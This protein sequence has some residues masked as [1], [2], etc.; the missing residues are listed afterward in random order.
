MTAELP[1][2]LAPFGA[3]L[4]PFPR[5]LAEALGAMVGRLRVLVGPLARSEDAPEGELDGLSG[6]ARRG[7]LERLLVTDWALL[8]HEPDELLR[9]LATGELSYLALARRQEVA[10]RRTIALFDAGPAQLGGPR[11]AHLALA[12]LL[13]ARADAAGASFS[14]GSLQ[15]RRL[16]DGFEEASARALLDARTRADVTAED[17]AWWTE[18]LAATKGLDLWIV[19]AGEGPAL[20]ATRVLLDDAEEPGA[21]AVRVR[22]RT[23]RGDERAA[24]V[25]LPPTGLA[26]RLLR[27]PFDVPRRPP[28]TAP[29]RRPRRSEL[30]ERRL[31]FSPDG[32][33]LWGRFR[34]DTLCSWVAMK[35]SG[36]PVP[37]RWFHAPDGLVAAVTRVGHVTWV[38][39]ERAG[40]ALEVHT[41]SRRENVSLRVKHL[42]RTGE[43]AMLPARGSPLAAAHLLP[44]GDLVFVDPGMR[45]VRIP[46]LASPDVD[47]VLRV[48]SAPVVALDAFRERA[49]TA[50]GEGFS[51]VPDG[52]AA[53][54]VGRFDEVLPGMG[55]TRATR[56]GGAWTLSDGKG[57]KAVHVEPGETV[58]GPFGFGP[59]LGL[60]V[61]DEARRELVQVSL[62]G[63]RTSRALSSEPI[64]WAGASEHAPVFA[65]LAGAWL[66]LSGPNG[67]IARYPLPEE[68]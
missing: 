8:E 10:D 36:G 32:R 56:R 58:I 33:R 11:L 61:L 14:F 46:Q 54:L 19:G 28:S 63:E 31:V 42:H 16:L 45:L 4:A 38:V 22:I 65:Y 35:S 6:L 57:E 15:G 44:T 37:E 27:R 13:A 39:V 48:A 64:R 21:S 30:D 24:E 68:P 50:D 9:R 12:I 49:I 2:E 5:D 51:L 52:G 62:L 7:P 1:R 66:T 67:T 34:D 40:G 23:P 53:P 59:R 3:L 26:V 29:F 43:Q 55:G 18:A 25:P 60:L 47:V 17:R 41:L 20:P